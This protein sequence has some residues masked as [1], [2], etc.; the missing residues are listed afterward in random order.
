M[1]MT[2]RGDVELPASRETVWKALND[3]A[4]LKACIPG[5][6]SLEKLD[7]NT[8]QATARIKAG[9][10]AATFKGK[11][12]LLDL[13]PP[14]G[15]RIVGEG[16]GGASGFAKGAATVKLEALSNGTRLSYDVEAQIGGKLA[17][18]GGRLFDAVA[19][20]MADQFFAKFAAELGEQEVGGRAVAAEAPVQA[21][22]K[23]W[24]RRFL[25]WLFGGGK[26][27]S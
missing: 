21:P 25:E 15:Y 17:Q 23:G 11:I 2:M 22:G 6:E 27:R 26:T 8:M 20:K 9:P 1:A 19:K 18:L 24:F 7:D 4:I 13:D 14:N 5:C 3:P 12:N 10:V 16:E